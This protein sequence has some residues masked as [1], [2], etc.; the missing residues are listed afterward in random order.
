MTPHFS[1][2]PA[3]VG[4]FFDGERMRP[5]PGYFYGCWIT[6][7]IVGPWKGEPGTEG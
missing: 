1:F 4:C 7:E 3:R 5:Q 6:D 2:Y